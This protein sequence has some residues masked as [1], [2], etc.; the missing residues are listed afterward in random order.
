L[1]LNFVR[2]LFCWFCEYFDR[3]SGLLRIV[4][5]PA[6]HTDGVGVRPPIHN[7]ESLEELTPVRLRD[8]C[9]KPVVR[10]A[11]RMTA[12]PAGWRGVR[13]D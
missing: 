10:T 7:I 9:G 4:Q 11:L 2:C 5:K 12:S 13:L 6:Q 8:L 1:T 3:L